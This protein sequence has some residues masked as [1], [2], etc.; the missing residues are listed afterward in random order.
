MR[1]EKIRE[2]MQETIVESVVPKTVEHPAEYYRTVVVIPAFNEERFIGSVVIQARKHAATVIVVDD[3]SQDDTAEIAEVAGALVIQHEVNSGKGMALNTGFRRARQISDVEVIV[4]VDGDG[5]HDCG[6]IPQLVRPIF[7]GEA[8]MVVGSRFLG[9]KSRIPRWRVFGQHALTL[10]TNLSSNENLT[11]SQSGFRAFSNKVLDVFHFDSRGFSV[12]SE[13]QFMMHDVGLRVKEV[14]ISVVYEEPPKRNPVIHGLQ[15]VNGVLRLVGQYR[16]LLYFGGGGLAIL[17]VGLLWGV[18]VVQIY[19]R[20]R[21]LAVGYAL[22]S[23]LLMV[24]GST[25]LFT[26]VMLHSVI[27][28]IKDIK[29]AFERSRED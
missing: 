24:V 17:T 19:S 2:V 13:M 18:Y 16:P 29:K 6:E 14:P 4:T 23:V 22:I 28:L 7:A 3:G 25:A 9:R 8:D 21:T 11:D 5:Q 26:G 20:A 15:V 1:D 10:A 27:G 12:E